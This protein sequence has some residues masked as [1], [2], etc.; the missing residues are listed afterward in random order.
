V[1][2]ALFGKSLFGKSFFVDLSLRGDAV[3][4]RNLQLSR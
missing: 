1:F 3:A 4:L 2:S